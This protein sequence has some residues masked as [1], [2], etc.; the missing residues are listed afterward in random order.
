[1]GSGVV[2]KCPCGC[3]SIDFEIEGLGKAPRGVHIL[4][5]FIYGDESNLSGVF[6]FEPAGIL[7]GLEVTGYAVDT[8][9]NLPNPS[10]LQPITYF[11][12]N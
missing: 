2:G 7:S 8:P 6:V 3:A 5:D 10:N 11:K 4:G 1:M 9:K 12:P